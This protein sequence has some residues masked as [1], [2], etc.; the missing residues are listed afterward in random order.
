MK[1]QGVIAVSLFES[2]TPLE[3]RF[4]EGNPWQDIAYF[5]LAEGQAGKLSIQ[6]TVGAAP[7]TRDEVVGLMSPFYNRNDLGAAVDT[8]YEK[9]LR[10]GTSRFK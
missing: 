9:A 5:S 4:A 7:L 8:I 3:R 1:K 2:S 6:P 10:L